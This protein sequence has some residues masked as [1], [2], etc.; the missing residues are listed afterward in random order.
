M[1]KYHFPSGASLYL[2]LVV[3]CLVIAI[4]PAAW[5]QTF[6][7]DK[8]KSMVT[9]YTVIIDMKIEMSFGVHSNEQE[10]KYLGTIVTDGG[11]VIFNGSALNSDN[12]LS[13]FSGF[14][15]KTTPTSISVTT[16]DGTQYDAEFVGVDR[17]TDIGFIRLKPTSPQKFKP[18][19]FVN[20][21]SFR[22][23]SWLTLYMLLPDFVNPPLAA[24]IGMVN[25]NLK[26]PEAFPLIVGFNAFQITSVLFNEQLEPVGV[27]GV[28]NDPSSN[29]MDAS[30]M[31]DSFGQVG[32]QLLGVVTADKLEKLIADPPKKGMT[33]R[34]WLGITLQAL[35]PD[36]AKFWGLDLSS[37]IIVNDVVKGSPAEAGGMKVGDIIY[38][39][40][41]QPV[42]V[43]KEEKVPIFQ[44][45]IADMGP[46]SAVEF[47]V[48]RRTGDNLDSL[49]VLANLE[50]APMTATDA[51]EYEDSTL[52]FNVRGMVFADYL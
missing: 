1:S 45:K 49:Q 42:E 32:I 17:F 11:L 5:T 10:D 36:M 37:G 19:K 29:N 51:P 47:S 23:G 28:L 20:Q 24:D 38:A 6:D 39:V 48:I 35:T 7:Y 9:P 52:E 22:V 27:L 31:M 21:S 50:K 2:S 16:L 12:A 18:V 4:S 13:T 25:A 40:N 26:S 33:D 46:G 14:S 43:D 34:G 44:R 41:G 8:L 15:V 30:S 3:A